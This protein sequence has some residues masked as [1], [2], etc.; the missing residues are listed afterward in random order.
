MAEAKTIA[1]ECLR[2]AAAGIEVAERM[3]V[4]AD[5]N[6]MLEMAQ[7]WLAMAKEAEA[8]AGSQP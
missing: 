2:Q 7:R 8:K 5:R 4:A 1:A 6:R 3:S